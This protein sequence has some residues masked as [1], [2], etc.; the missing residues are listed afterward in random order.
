MNPG[1]LPRPRPYWHVDAKWICGLL[2]LV[3]LSLTFLVFVLHQI[4]AAGRGIRLL[5][6]FLASAYV[7]LGMEDEGDL[8]QARQRIAA[9]PNGEWQPIPG[10]EIRVRQGDIA[11]LS[12]R[13]ARL[14]FFRQLA[15]PLYF[16][17]A[18]GL[19]RLAT[20]PQTRAGL[21]QGIG[22][23]DFISQ[24][25]HGQAQKALLV[26]GLAALLLGAA[27][28]FFSFRFGRLV[29]PGCVIFLAALPGLLLFEAG[30]SW[31]AQP[32]P[33]DGAGAE[34]F[35]GL[36]FNQIAKEAFPEAIGFGWR[37]YL[38]LV[39]LGLGLMVLAL[40]GSV[41]RRKQGNREEEQAE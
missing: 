16:E 36:R 18:A 29:S 34:P 33:L 20:G 37:V 14:W 38:A 10:L 19:A 6:S 8:E 2:L 7:P 5:T 12:P 17:G 11:G 25:T 27:L 30:R 21:A 32:L 28:V 39:L 41:L 35:L 31:L 22:P 26:G 40:L 24:Q 1:N 9:A 3:V 13:Q 15:E 23:L 4:T